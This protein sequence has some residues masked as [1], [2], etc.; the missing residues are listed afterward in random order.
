M[1]SL[2]LA[3]NEAAWLVSKSLA[4]DH[5][6]WRLWEDLEGIW[7]GET[8]GVDKVH[9]MTIL[10]SF[11]INL[12]FQEH[13]CQQFRSWRPSKTTQNCSCQASCQP[14]IPSSP[15]LV[16][17]YGLNGESILWQIN[18]HPYNHAKL[19][20]LLSYHAVHGIVTEAFGSLAFVFCYFNPTTLIPILSLDQSRLSLE[21]PWTFQ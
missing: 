8:R 6:Q 14:G 20:S 15:L 1:I 17:W 4:L 12:L 3:R 7:T 9:L 19:A 11:V 21:D 18:L 13:R 10:L 5:R 2:Y 16:Y